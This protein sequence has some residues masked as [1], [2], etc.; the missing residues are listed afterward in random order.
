M[1]P[2]FFLVA[3]R[4]FKN[5]IKIILITLAVL[6][7]MPL[8]AVVVIAN[9]G[10]TEVAQAL[11]GLNPITHKVEVKD[12]NGN[13]ITELELSTVW[14]TYGYVSDEF[15]SFTPFRHGLGL[16]PHTGIDIAS[17]GGRFGEP[18]T[19]FMAGRVTDVD[20]IDD[21]ACGKHV[22]ISHGNNIQS[23]Y[24]HMDEATAIDE[25]DVQPGDVIGLM[26]SSGTS[27]GAHLHFQVEVFGIPVNPRIF[28]VGE[29]LGGTR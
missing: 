14:P 17:F 24:C 7:A 16:G 12:P 10:I 18:V 22:R 23:V 6:L 3:A 20:N 11:V 26:G 21:S 25:S 4:S 2:L 5:E 29:P 27:S 28:M 9:A 15:G 13:V 19:P 8:M 1:K